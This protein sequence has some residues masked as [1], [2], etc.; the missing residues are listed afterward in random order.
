M[1]IKVGDRV[2]HGGHEFVVINVKHEETM[3]GN[4]L[5]IQCVDPETADHMQQNAMKTSQ[6][7]D[8]MLD[9]LRKLLEKGK[10]EFGI[11]FMGGSGGSET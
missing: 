8:N 3:E 9:T 1:N 4:G 2:S 11:G 5:L 7:N 10:G 6:V